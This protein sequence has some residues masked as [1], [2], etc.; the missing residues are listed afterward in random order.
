MHFRRPQSD[1]DLIVR[2]DSSLSALRCLLGSSQ[3]SQDTDHTPAE[4][5]AETPTSQ[6]D[7]DETQTPLDPP[8][9]LASQDVGQTP[10]DPF[11]SP[12]NA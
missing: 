5:P 11:R 8:V 6:E 2:H 12:G 4:T 10:E 3:S 9:D 1:R 7:V